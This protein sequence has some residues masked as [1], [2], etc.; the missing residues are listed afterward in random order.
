MPKELLVSDESYNSYN[1]RVVTSGGD[2]RRFNNNPI[3]LFN[4]IRVDGSKGKDAILPIGNWTNLR[5]D[6][7]KLF[8]TPVFDDNG[9]EFAERI[10]KKYEK[11]IIRSA[12]LGICPLRVVRD[13]PDK[14]GRERYSITEWELMEISVADIPS[15]S[16]AVA[17]YDQD[18]QPI[19]L[20][21]VI[22]MAAHSSTKIEAKMSKYQNIPAL[23]GLNADA[24]EESVT[25]KVNSLVRL[26]AENANLKAENERLK[27][28]AKAI[29][30]R[31][32]LQL[33]DQAVADK[34]ILPAA[35]DHFIKLLNVDFESA[36]A[37]MES[38]G[39]QVNLSDIPSKKV[40]GGQH[41]QQGSGPVK[42]NGMT[43]SEMQRKA[44]GTLGELKANNFSLFNDLYKSE[45]GVDYR[46]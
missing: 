19:E 32:I 12:S 33:V 36:K 3:M 10:S 40:P 6:G 35:K 1:I 9:D 5:P 16:N 30:D 25:E 45:F 27:N 2:F 29:R 22:T 20:N 46:V 41:S 23:L 4:H 7:N 26:S 13:E 31:E 44:S 17:F 24:S 21:A 43:F 8:A 18:N 38:M 15:N 39:A 28:E 14:Y 37:M 34:K 42:H 11:G